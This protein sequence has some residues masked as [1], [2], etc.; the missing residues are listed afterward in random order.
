MLALQD[1]GVGDEDDDDQSGDCLY[2]KVNGDD[3]VSQSLFSQCFLLYFFQVIEHSLNLEKLKTLRHRLS[4]GLA[5]LDA[6]KS[7]VA[8]EASGL[9]R[10]FSE[11]SEKLEEV[12]SVKA[13]AKTTTSAKHQQ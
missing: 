1:R 4:E 5:D 9:G 3:L 12:K 13:F 10:A 2:D 7:G 6:S 11:V 8:E